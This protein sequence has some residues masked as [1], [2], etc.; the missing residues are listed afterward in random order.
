MV[1]NS[2]LVNKIF[3][4]YFSS[5]GFSLTFG[6]L[7][8]IRGEERSYLVSI[9]ERDFGLMASRFSP[10][11]DDG[12]AF[13]GTQKAVLGEFCL[14]PPPYLKTFFLKKNQKTSLRYPH[15]C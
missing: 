11:W 7:T 15:T 3:C 6:L 8:Q 1:V 12:L 2:C 10:I 14:P 4:T 9:S 13:M 5:N